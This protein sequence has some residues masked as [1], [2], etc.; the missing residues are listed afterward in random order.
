MESVCLLSVFLSVY[1][2]DV[3]S[4]HVP[5]SC[6]DFHQLLFVQL[7]PDVFEETSE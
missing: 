6:L 7:S 2:V 5:I 1:E 3:I 4:R